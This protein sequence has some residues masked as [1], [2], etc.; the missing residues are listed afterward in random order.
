MYS[1]WANIGL[2]LYG[3]IIAGI[4]YFFCIILGKALFEDLIGGSI[5]RTRR[6]MKR[7]TEIEKDHYVY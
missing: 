7:K 3:A 4:L 2:L 5:N 6:K 1:L